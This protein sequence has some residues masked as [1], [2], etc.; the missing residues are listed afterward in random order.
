LRQTLSEW[1]TIQTTKEGREIKKQLREHN[2][3]RRWFMSVLVQEQKTD[4]NLH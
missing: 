3:K 4:F 1:G 2:R